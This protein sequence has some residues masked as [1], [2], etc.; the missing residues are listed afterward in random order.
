VSQVQQAC[1]GIQDLYLYKILYGYPKTY[2]LVQLLNV[3]TPEVV[4]LE[5]ASSREALRMAEEIR[6]HAPKTAV[7]GYAERRQSPQ[8]QEV[9]EAGVAHVLLAPFDGETFQQA[10]VKV[11]APGYSGAARTLLAFLPA[12]AGSGAT[13]AALHVAGSLANQ[14]KQKV[15]VLEADLHSGT[16]AFQLNLNHDRS[17]ADALENAPQLGEVLWGGLPVATQGL[18]VLPAPKTHEVSRYS[19][20]N[21]QLL[22]NFATARYDAVVADLPEIVDEASEPI[23]TQAKGVYLVTAP[24]RASLFLARK[25]ISAL[26]A[27][28]VWESHIHVVLNRYT[29]RCAKIEEIEQILERRV[30]V[31]LPEDSE[32]RRWVLDA[33][34]ANARSVLRKTFCAFARTAA[35]MTAATSP[36]EA[37][38]SGFRALF[39]PRA[40]QQP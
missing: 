21:Y 12:K 9:M 24:E 8:L 16:M 13:T 29:G 36:L 1:A 3:F 38:R 27:R 25:R 22:L 37:G 20:W 40:W 33:G 11:L 15:L 7:V 26:Q 30:T 6:V 31:V 35:G 4:F 19:R 39:R 14:W 28:G 18:D 34:M 17:I 23:L 5:V 10:V 32:A 2:E